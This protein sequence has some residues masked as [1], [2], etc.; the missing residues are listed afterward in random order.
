MKIITQ[1]DTELFIYKNKVIETDRK[2]NKIFDSVLPIY[3]GS[4]IHYL[5]DHMKVKKNST[6]LDLCSGSGVLGIYSSDNASK[7]VLSDISSKAIDFSKRNA[8]RNGLTNIE[9]RKGDLFN[10]VKNEKFDYILTNPPFVPVP[11]N[12]KAALHSNGGIDGFYLVKKIF[13]SINNHLK[14]NGKMYMYTLSLGDSKTSLL[15]EYIKSNFKKGRFKLTSMYSK[16]LPLEVF[17]KDFK[18]YNIKQWKS[19]LEKESYTHLYSYIIEFENISK[20]LIVKKSVIKKEE[21]KTYP[22][23]WKNW[24]SR[25]SY[26]ILDK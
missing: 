10:T 23:N 11:K 18:K 14:P 7:V 1:K 24:K 12:I 8:Y 15:E 9:F 6:V 5:I 22:D 3:A 19:S 21:R 2:D 17:F 20:P 25:F 16:P 4:G 13:D 26:W